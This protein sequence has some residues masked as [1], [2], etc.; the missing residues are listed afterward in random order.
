MALDQVHTDLGAEGYEVESLIIPAC[1]VDAPHRRDR[2][3]IVGHAK[4]DGLTASKAGG[5]L[6]DES[7]ESGRK[8]E[9]REL[10]GASGASAGVADANS[11]QL[12]KCESEVK[13]IQMPCE[14]SE[15]VGVLA[16]AKCGNGK[17]FGQNGLLG[18]S[19]QERAAR[20]FANENLQGY[21]K[22]LPEPDVGRVAHGIPNRAHR[23]KGLGNAIVPQV[24]YQI[25]KGIRELL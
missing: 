11:G 15:R 4:L 7:K 16:N 14:S 13:P 6:F 8:V 3:W 9:E 24:A 17:A 25:T 21:R 19:N 18:K 23:L 22:W 2:V 1:A 10:A 20:G 5:G 12:G